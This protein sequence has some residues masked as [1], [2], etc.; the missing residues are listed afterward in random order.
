MNTN[1]LGIINRI[2]AQYGEGILGDAA[3]LKGIVNDLAKTESKEDRVAFGRAV[4]QG[5][6][7][8]LKRAAPQDRARVK[9]ALVSRL[10][11]VTGFDAPRCTAAVDLLE[12]AMTGSVQPAY[13]QQAAPYQPLQANRG[14]AAFSLHNAL[15]K[16]KI[17]RKSFIFGAAAGAGAL[18]GEL[19]SELFRL[20]D[21]YQTSFFS[22]C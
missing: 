18:V 15:A 5:F 6:Y 11:S 8:E 7:H 12:A 2:T 20:N 14:R 17:S 16:G 13:Q 3:R 10:Q 9:A 1:L 19:V 22:L 4:E 21:G